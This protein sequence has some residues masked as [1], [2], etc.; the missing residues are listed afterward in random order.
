MHVRADPPKLMIIRHGTITLF[1]PL[2]YL[3]GKIVSRTEESHTHV[4]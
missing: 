1:A 4:E 3:E 2:S